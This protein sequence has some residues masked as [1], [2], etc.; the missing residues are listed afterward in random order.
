MTVINRL[1]FVLLLCLAVGG[2]ARESVL[3]GKLTDAKGQPLA[4]VKLTAKQTQPVKNCEQFET[5][6]GPEGVFRLSGLCPASEYT[7]V[8]ESKEWSTPS[9]LVLQ[10]APVGQTV[11]IPAPFI[12]RFMIFGNGPIIDTHTG[13]MWVPAPDRDVDWNQADAY[14][15][16]LDT[17]GYKDWRL[18][19][20]AELRTLYDSSPKNQAGIDPAFGQNVT[21]A[22]SGECKGL[23]AR[24][25]FFGLG[26]ENANIMNFSKDF[27]VLAV[28][29]TK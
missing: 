12:V 24:F 18:P 9:A 13:L 15:R 1:L 23:F 19:S 10:S 29:T 22:W 20:V 6:T 17:G 16:S 27:K 8:P 5:L 2:C 28:R 4:N 14:A 21:R 11:T 7:L 25:F 26:I 3:E